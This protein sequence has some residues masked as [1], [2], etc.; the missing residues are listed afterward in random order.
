VLYFAYGSNLNWQRMRGRCPSSKP[1][2]RGILHGWQLEFR[3]KHH[4]TGVANIFE[5]KGN[6]VH[7]MLYEI[8]DCEDWQHLDS[9]EGVPSTYYKKWVEV[10]TRQGTELAITYVMNRKLTPG[11]NKLPSQEY[12]AHLAK[13]YDKWVLPLQEIDKAINITSNS[14]EGSHYANS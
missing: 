8:E 14:K 10:E 9:C 2:A 1:I 11:Y 3:A 12:I 5:D 4:K 7:G 6:K 13:G